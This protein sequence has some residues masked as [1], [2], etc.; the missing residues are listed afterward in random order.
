M[1]FGNAILC[2]LLAP[3]AVGGQVVINEIHYNSEPNTSAE[4]FVELFNT[5]PD[6]VDV[7]GWFFQQGINFTIPPNTKIASGA[8]LVISEDPATLLTNFGVTA[9]G[10][11]SGA[12][13]GDGETVELR[14]ADGQTVDEVNY[15][16][17]FPWPVGASGSG[18]SMELI[19]PGL[20]DGLG[21][22]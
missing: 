14:S 11:Y 18:S 16:V 2:A 8:F 4:E 10:P 20:D 6:E 17:G 12:L 5:G 22:A 19:N 13:S 9:L 1:K 21:A 3:T 7:S 15:G